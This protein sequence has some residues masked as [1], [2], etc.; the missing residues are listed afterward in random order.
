M[1]NI[2]EFILVSKFQIDK[3]TIVESVKVGNINQ[4]VMDTLF[5]IIQELDSRVK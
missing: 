4:S 3:N 2:K 5:K 1:K